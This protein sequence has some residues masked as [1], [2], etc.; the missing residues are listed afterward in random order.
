MKYLITTNTS[1]PF[2]TNWFDAENHFNSNIGMI[3]YDLQNQKY[4]I[5]GI[6]WSE[7]LIDKL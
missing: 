5:D 2:F 1:E 7:I 3:V 4:T 6:N